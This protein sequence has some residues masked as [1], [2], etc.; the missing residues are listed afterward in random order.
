MSERYIASVD[1]GTASSRCLIFDHEGRVVSV[2]QVEHRQIVPRPGH[3]EH[4]PVEIWNNVQY[5]VATAL[6]TADLRAS[7]LV[8]LGLTNQRESQILL[9]LRQFMEHDAVPHG[10]RMHVVPRAPHI[11]I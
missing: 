7:D 3:V 8:G 6:A 4:D 5:V 9:M 10:E 11:G 2:S 1:Q